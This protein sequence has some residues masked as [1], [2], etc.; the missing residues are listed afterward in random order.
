MYNPD[1]VQ[2]MHQ[3]AYCLF[4]SQLIFTRL[5]YVLNLLGFKGYYAV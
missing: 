5:E 4:S 3:H 2:K 1:L